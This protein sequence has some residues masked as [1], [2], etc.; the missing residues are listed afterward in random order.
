MQRLLTQLESPVPQNGTDLPASVPQSS[1]KGR[2]NEK[3]RK[4][5]GKKT[6]EQIGRTTDEKT[7]EVPGLATVTHLRLSLV[8]WH[9]VPRAHAPPSSSHDEPAVSL[10]VQTP[11][12]VAQKLRKNG[13]QQR[14]ERKKQKGKKDGQ[15]G[16]LSA[17]SFSPPLPCA[18]QSQA[19]PDRV[20]RPLC[21]FRVPVL[22]A[23]D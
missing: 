13:F 5:M 19:G 7:Q 14:R 17:L 23:V 11:V 20:P 10:V 21:R 4:A 3:K 12:R 15:K 1:P 8:P 9:R 6:R 18:R 16:P 2:K 22:R